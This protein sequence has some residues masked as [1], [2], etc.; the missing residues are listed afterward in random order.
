MVWTIAAAFFFFLAVSTPMMTLGLLG[1]FRTGMIGSGPMMLDNQGYWIIATLVFLTT[2]VAPFLK[3]AGTFAV[4]LGLRLRRYLAV[5]ARLYAF[6]QHLDDWVMIDVYLLGILV[7]YSR[8]QGIGHVEIEASL[9]GLAGLMVS[10][11]AMDRCMDPEAVWEKIK[12]RAVVNVGGK[13]IGCDT[14]YQVAYANEGEACP[15]CFE[16]L[17]HRKPDSLQRTSALALTAAILYIPSNFLPIMRIAQI[18]KTTTYTIYG[19]LMELSRV[20]LWPLAVLV[21]IASIAIPVFK[22]LALG[23]MLVETRFGT[24]RN[25]RQRSHLYNILHF[26]GKWSMVDIYVVSILVAL[27]HFGWL[28]QISAESGGVYFAGVVIITLLAVK[29]FD[30]RLM[31]DAAERKPQPSFVFGVKKSA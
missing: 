7:A 11:V 22:L 6:M 28:T 31:W 19:G 1:N 29:S 2:I 24:A 13:V 17:R 5:L 23:F 12:D 16:I 14:C 9:I 10:V 30:P 3:I 25:L 26:I 4:L 8:L 18:N 20:G 27:V 21:F 15:R